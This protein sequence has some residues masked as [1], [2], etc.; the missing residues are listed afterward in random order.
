MHWIS[1]VAL[2]DA[3]FHGQKVKAGETVYNVLGSANRDAEYYEDPDTF[4][5]DRPRS[6]HH[7]FGHGIHF[8]IGAPLARMEAKQAI[9]GM[10]ERY[11]SVSHT[12]D[13]ENEPTHSTMLRGYHHLWLNLGA[14]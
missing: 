10:L 11:D 12:P 7:T 8:C 9:V 2:S 14:R 5:L 4:R 1:R 3:E 13:G 6:D